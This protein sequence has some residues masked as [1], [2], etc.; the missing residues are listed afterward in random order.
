MQS[1]VTN[2][3][4][5][6][7]QFESVLLLEYLLTDILRFISGQQIFWQHPNAYERF[8]CL[9]FSVEKLYLQYNI[10]NSLRCG[11][12]WA[13]EPIPSRGADMKLHCSFHV[14]WWIIMCS[15]MLVYNLMIT[16]CLELLLLRPNW[17][18]ALYGSII[19]GFSYTSYDLKT[20]HCFVAYLVSLAFF[21]ASRRAAA[22]AR[23]CLIMA[24]RARSA[25]ACEVLPSA[26]RFM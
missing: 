24:N 23:C 25:L 21:S 5:E 9:N 3:V 20:T 16:T 18:R 19:L 6:N 22:S 15:K 7:R 17:F 14:L 2:S 13:W 4:H 8:Q 26:C 11:I 12:Y 1:L 10:R